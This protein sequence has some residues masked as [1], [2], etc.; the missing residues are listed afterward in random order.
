[1]DEFPPNL[2]NE[3]PLNPPRRWIIGGACLVILLFLLATPAGLW[4]KLDAVGYAI[5][6]QIPERSFSFHDRPLPL[7]ARCTGTFSAALLVVLTS[8]VQGR[9]RASHLP[10]FRVALT[11]LG[12]MLVW[13]LDGLN[14]YLALIDMPHLYEP[15]NGLRFATG[16][17]NGIA[18]GN[19]VLPI[20]NL[21][22]WRRPHPRPN[23]KNMRELALLVGLVA[24]FDGG[25]LGLGGPL[26]LLAAG[27][28]TLG[29]LTMLTAVNT[30]IALILLRWEN[31]AGSPSQAL[32][33]VLVGLALSLVMVL[34]V[35]AAR[36]MLI[37]D[38]RLPNP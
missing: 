19:L 30:V 21:S 14:S 12:F 2:T 23:L 26:Y 9:G 1:M 20:F 10:P 8:V 5:C 35:G 37:G 17:L 22:M 25:V 32:A 27:A 11:L 4:E 13:A 18:L 6:H 24:L 36:T 3:Q 28:S 33:P 31:R 15:H 16:S 29:V 38:L 7:C 34:G